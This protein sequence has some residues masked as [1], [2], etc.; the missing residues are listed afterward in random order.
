GVFEPLGNASLVR[1][2]SVSTEKALENAIY[3]THR[4]NLNTKFSISTGLRYSLYSYI[5][6][7]DVDYYASDAPIS[8]GT[9]TN[10]VSYSKGK[11]INNYSGPEI[12]FSLKY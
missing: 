1:H 4:F 10:T 7:Q 8:D 5:G 3:L 6:P 12:R 9:R 2:D 11:F